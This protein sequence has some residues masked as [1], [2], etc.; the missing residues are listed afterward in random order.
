MLRVSNTQIIDTECGD[1][2]EDDDEDDGDDDGV[3]DF[4]AHRSRSNDIRRNQC[5]GTDQPM[6]AATFPPEQLPRQR[7]PSPPDSMSFQARDGFERHETTLSSPRP[8]SKRQ[9][10]NASPLR[11]LP[12]LAVSCPSHH[13]SINQPMRAGAKSIAVNG[14]STRTSTPS[15]SHGSTHDSR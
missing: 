8:M 2:D 12:S 14:I 5:M 10:R 9:R 3:V 11:P 1:D 4:P 13:Q 7:S 6:R 15:S